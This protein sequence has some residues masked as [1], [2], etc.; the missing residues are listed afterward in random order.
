ME[1]V[2]L[3]CVGF[4]AVGGRCCH[5]GIADHDPGWMEVSIE[6]GVDTESGFGG[7]ADQVDG[8]LVA[9]RARS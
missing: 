8:D 9:G 3:F 6:F 1:G 4:V 2:V 7:G 5:W